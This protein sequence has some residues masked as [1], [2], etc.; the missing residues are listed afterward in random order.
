VPSGATSWDKTSSDFPR[1]R[2]ETM[3]TIVSSAEISR[4]PED[5]FAYVTDPSHLPEWQ[6]SVVSVEHDDA[7]VHVGKKA[8]VTRQAGPRKMASTAEVTE[9]EP[10]RTWSIRGV[11]GPVRGNVKGRIEPLDEGARSRVTIE[12]DLRGH[13][14]GKLLLPLVVSRQAKREM[15]QNMQR[16][17]ERLESR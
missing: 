16:L 11:D 14:I 1:K 8:V 6:A 17:K 15:P 7:P 5:V 10:P 4:T 2:R 9:L 12:L 3:T 13:G